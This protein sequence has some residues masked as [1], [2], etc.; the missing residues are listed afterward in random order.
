MSD[1]SKEVKEALDEFDICENLILSN[2]DA[3]K[4]TILA[5]KTRELGQ[6]FDIDWKTF[7]DSIK[8]KIIEKIKIPENMWN[9]PNYTSVLDITISIFDKED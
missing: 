4:L 7:Y 9:E 1:Y 6:E 5:K 2:T 8:F 3:V